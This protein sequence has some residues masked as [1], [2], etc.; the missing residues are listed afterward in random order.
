MRTGRFICS[1]LEDIRL[2][3]RSKNYQMIDQ[4]VEEAQILANRMEG[5]LEYYSQLDYKIHDIESMLDRKAELKK[6]ILELR[7]EKAECRLNCQ[8]SSEK[9]PE[10]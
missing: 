1:V 4:L 8:S 9:Q 5:Q 6:E 3:N 7:L 10:K 2:A